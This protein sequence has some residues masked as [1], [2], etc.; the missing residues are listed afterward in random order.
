MK[1]ILFF[2][3]C[4]ILL[5]TACN[6]TTP[7]F[8]TK[9]STTEPQTEKSTDRTDNQADPDNLKFEDFLTFKEHTS[10]WD[11][12]IERVGYPVP[13]PFGYVPID[14]PFYWETSEGKV[15]IVF[16]EEQLI[17][18]IDYFPNDTQTT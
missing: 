8:E 2:L 6:P 12:V 16:D 10:T 14:Y 18:S 1:K 9:D 5:L 3:L 15:E 11:E 7:T 17:V 4:T 13:D